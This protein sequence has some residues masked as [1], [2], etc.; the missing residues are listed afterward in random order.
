MIKIS[1]CDTFMDVAIAMVRRLLQW[2]LG[3]LDQSLSKFAR[4]F[5]AGV[6]APKRRKKKHVGFVM[7]F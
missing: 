1:F 4:K 3:Y 2:T 5:P 7:H 6:G